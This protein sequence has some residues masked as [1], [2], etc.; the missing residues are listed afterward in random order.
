MPPQK[1]L[2]LD[3]KKRL[4]P[5]P[6]HPSQN[7]QQQPIYLPVCRLLDLSTEDTQLVS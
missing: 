7:H 2:R 4:F 5:G 1:R 6:N 3:K